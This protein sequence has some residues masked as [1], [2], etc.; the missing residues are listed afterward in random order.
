MKIMSEN[1]TDKPL[2][3][4]GEP[5]GRHHERAEQRRQRQGEALRANLKRRKDASR[6]RQTPV[7]KD[8]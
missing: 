3:R 1:R 4:N 6:Q 5:S 8:V 2:R 7:D